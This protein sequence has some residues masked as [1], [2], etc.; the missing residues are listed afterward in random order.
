MLRPPASLSVKK[1]SAPTRIPERPVF[2]PMEWDEPWAVPGYRRNLPHWRLEGAT[3]FITFRLADSIPESVARHWHE[4]RV[5]WLRQQGL[6]PRLA[7]GDPECLHASKKE[8]RVL[9]Y[10]DDAVPMLARM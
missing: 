3:Y 4:E 2:H 6:D 5:A 10:V 7:T 1:L 9:D 8:V